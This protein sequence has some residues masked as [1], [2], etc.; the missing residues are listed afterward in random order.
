GRF[1]IAV[2]FAEKVKARDMP[3]EIEDLLLIPDEKLSADQRQTLLHH[4]ASIAPELAAARKEIEELRKQLPAIPTTLVMRERPADNPRPTFRHNRGEFLQPKE[5]VQPGTL[6]IL[7]PLPTG[8]PANRL[9]FAR[10]LV[11]PSNPLVGRVTVNRQWQ[12]FFGRG[13]VRT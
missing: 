9:T 11:S 12:A 1:R 8:Q 3:A 7:P 13:L 10:W 5:P 6:S 2:T 4:W